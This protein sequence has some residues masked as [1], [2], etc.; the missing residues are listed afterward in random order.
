MSYATGHNSL[1]SQYLLNIY[2]Y[3]RFCRLCTINCERKE[4]ILLVVWLGYYDTLEEY[5]T[6]A[7]I[8]EEGAKRVTMYIHSGWFA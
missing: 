1:T 2:I 5:T 3:C 6:F 4:K 7:S 8:V